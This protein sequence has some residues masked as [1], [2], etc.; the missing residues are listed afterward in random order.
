MGFVAERQGCPTM[1]H[2][3]AC[4]LVHSR[5]ASSIRVC[6]PWPATANGGLGELLRPAD[7]GVKELR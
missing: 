4:S 7:P 5:R 3:V 6:H 2:A 1:G